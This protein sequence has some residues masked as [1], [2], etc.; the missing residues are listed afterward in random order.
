MAIRK[1]KLNGKTPLVV[2]VPGVGRGRSV[3]IGGYDFGRAGRGSIVSQWSFKSTGNGRCIEGDES[4]GSLHFPGQRQDSAKEERYQLR[5]RLAQS[6]TVQH[7]W[8]TGR[9][10]RSLIGGTTQRNDKER[11][12]FHSGVAKE[13]QLPPIRVKQE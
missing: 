7:L 1:K 4:D 2:C 5:P 6:I 12:G 3:R 10:P 13:G 9:A 11:D 8:A